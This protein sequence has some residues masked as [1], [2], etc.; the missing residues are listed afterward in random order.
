MI[1]P[2]FG[3]NGIW[4]AVCLFRQLNGTWEGVETPLPHDFGTYNRYDYDN[5][6]RGLNLQGSA[7][8]KKFT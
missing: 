1:C 6:T 3:D 5:F 4:I 2:T 7:K 8:S